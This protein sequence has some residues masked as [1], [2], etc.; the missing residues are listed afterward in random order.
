M[1][2]LGSGLKFDAA[3]EFATLFCTFL[4]FIPIFFFFSFFFL[5]LIMG[6]GGGGTPAELA[7]LSSPLAIQHY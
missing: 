4:N 6:G 3:V 2:H 1:E 5:F 7:I